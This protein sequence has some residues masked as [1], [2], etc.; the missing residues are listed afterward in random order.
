METSIGKDELC[1]GIYKIVTNS[2]CQ[3]LYNSHA[4]AELNANYEDV[5]LKAIEYVIDNLI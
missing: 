5:E 4:D 2:L 1:F 3:P